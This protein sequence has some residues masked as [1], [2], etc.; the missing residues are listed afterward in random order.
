[1]TADAG[2][3]PAGRWWSVRRPAGGRWWQ[4]EWGGM[5]VWAVVSTLLVI[6]GLL[7]A[8]MGLRPAPAADV[9]AASSP[10]VLFLGDSYVAGA[11]AS[12]PSRSWVSVVGAAEGWRV[13]NYARGGTGYVAEVSGEKAPNA[14]G[15]EDCPDFAAMAREGA[16]LLPDIVVVSGGR[17]DIG[18]DALDTGVAQFFA[19]LRETYPNSR[20][21]VTNV[22]WDATD[23]P[24][25]VAA[26]ADVVRAGAEG[27]GATWL[28]LGQ[29]LGSDTELVAPDGVHPDDAGHQA[30][31]DAV[32]AALD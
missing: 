7:W 3:V 17:N 10:V 1:M 30:I 6:P 26:L 14:C 27:I 32:L 29:P 23:P 22:L 20:I 19:L 31:A 28:D 13:R 18:A 9:A 21:Y 4:R 24:P 12:N 2:R 25:Q 16:A 11:G 15:R 5:P 8:G